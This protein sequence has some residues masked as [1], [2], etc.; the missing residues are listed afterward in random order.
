MSRDPRELYHKLEEIE[1][2][3]AATDAERAQA[4]EYMRRLVDKHGE[5]VKGWGR[6]TF[7]P[8]TP[9][10]AQLILHSAA[11]HGAKVRQE[12]PQMIVEGVP[13]VVARVR[14]DYRAYSEHLADILQVSMIAALK[15]FGVYCESPGSVGGPAA[16]ETKPAFPY[17]VQRH[18]ENLFHAA[19][20]IGRRF[21]RADY[22]R[23]QLPRPAPKPPPPPPAAPDPTDPNYVPERFKGRIRPIGVVEI[24]GRDMQVKTRGHVDQDILDAI[25]G[26]KTW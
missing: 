26:K 7:T 12:A 16:K 15:G 8:M 24:G 20:S 13:E 1:S 17:D 4:R 6:A 23:K 25:F 11:T 21:M 9:A 5:A 18:V 3:H 10:D 14:E 19:G 2:N 22:T